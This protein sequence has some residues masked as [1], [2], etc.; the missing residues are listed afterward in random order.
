M[1]RT[2]KDN[3]DLP[4]PEPVE[5]IRLSEQKPKLR[6]LLVVCLILLA[7][8]AFAYGIMHWLGK[9][10][11]WI[12][13]DVNSAA[14]LNCGSEFIFQYYLGDNGLSATAEHKLVSES[15]S[16]ACVKAYQLFHNKEIGTV[17]NVG[18]INAHPNEEIEVDEALYT[19]FEICAAYQNRNL[20][21]GPVY[22][23][24][25][26]LFYCE[27][28]WETASFDPAQ[29]EELKEFFAEVAAYAQNPDEVE[30]Q[31]LGNNRIR[32]YV[33][34]SYLK[35]AKEE[36]IS[37]FI[38]FYWMKNAFITD[39]LA[40]TMT[41]EGFT[42]GNISSY[43]GFV[44]NLDADSG[45]EYA[46]NLYDRTGNRVSLAGSMNYTGRKSIVYLRNYP[47]NSPDFQH[48]YEFEDGRIRM[49]YLDTKDG[50]ERTALNNLVCYSADAGCSEI[51]MEM[52][53]VY[54]TDE[55][56]ESRLSEAKKRGIC[57]VYFAEDELRFNEEA[58]KLSG[59]DINKILAFFE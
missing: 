24:Y 29:N 46:F 8:G 2:A 53:P 25:D 58:I 1:G 6:F 26:S 27:E 21:L 22:E 39:Y 4:H 32:L 15:Y 13:I 59:V 16:K 43:D 18:Y 45:T 20:Y 38:D 12:T 37:N 33:S 40:D 41:S 56:E 42:R 52:I 30:L 19:A 11:G 49:P 55:F 10:D 9:E 50:M 31:L 7:V 23:L 36:Y 3:R 17:H 44:R 14:E 48:Y 34:E 5:K 54:I 51:L 35:Y 28:D 57:S 47:M